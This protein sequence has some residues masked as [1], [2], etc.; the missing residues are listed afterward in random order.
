M[1]EAAVSD[2]ARAVGLLDILARDERSAVLRE[3]ARIEHPFPSAFLPGLFEA[4]VAR[5]PDGTAL[6]FGRSQ[7]TYAELNQRANR[8]AR[9]LVRQG[10]GP[11]TIVGVA[12][13]RSPELI[14]ALVGVLKAGGA[15]LPLDPAYPPARLDFMVEDANPALVLTTATIEPQLP[16]RI[17]RL[18]LDDVGALEEAGQGNDVNP[19]DADR[20]QPLAAD[21]PAYLTYTSGGTGTPKGV[22]L[23]HSGICALAASQCER[24]NLTARSRVLQLASPGFDDFIWEVAMALTHGAALVLMPPDAL[25]GPALRAALIEQRVTHATL[26]PA[27]LST[28]DIGDDLNLECLIVAR[29]PCPELWS[30]LGPADSA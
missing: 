3:C 6:V 17:S 15:Y 9:R 28:L 22:V 5:T 24:L 7:L 13:E 19:T 4:Q 8:L 30:P 23:T 11:E 10:V 12:I 20:R 14:V 25:S 27:V 21:H 2:S 29:E 1:L 18:V 16:A 26:P